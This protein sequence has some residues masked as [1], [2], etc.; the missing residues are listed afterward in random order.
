[1]FQD[2]EAS[3]EW[4]SSSLLSPFTLA[5]CKRTCRKKKKMRNMFIV[6]KVNRKTRMTRFQ[7]NY[8][9]AIAV[10]TEVVVGNRYFKSVSPQND[11]IGCQ[12]RYEAA[13][14]SHSLAPGRF[15]HASVGG[16]TSWPPAPPSLGSLE[17]TPASPTNA[18]CPC[19]RHTHRN[20]Q[21][22]NT[23]LDTR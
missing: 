18:L 10:S 23:S 17:S 9:C 21:R 11:L 15:W 7:F 14:C 8:L 6:V 1:M 12:C 13:V 3:S 16:G 22:Y 2:E 5:C 20:G 4:N 19:R